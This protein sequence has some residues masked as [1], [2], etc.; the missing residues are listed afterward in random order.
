MYVTDLGIIIASAGV[1]VNI[2]TTLSY[3]IFI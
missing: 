2:P 3:R 1:I